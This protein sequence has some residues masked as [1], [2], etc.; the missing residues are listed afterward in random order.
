MLRI[1]AI[2]GGAAAILFADQ[3]ARLF[4]GQILPLHHAA[5]AA[6]FIVIHKNAQKIVS[7]RKHRI[8]AAPDDHTGP[9][10][11]QVANDIG[12]RQKQRVVDGKIILCGRKAAHKISARGNCI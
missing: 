4:L 12:K 7:A 5:H 2:V 6:F 8:R 1:K 9:L 3:L 11:R 10:L